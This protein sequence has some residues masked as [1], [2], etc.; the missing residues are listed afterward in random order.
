MRSTVI[1]EG[2]LAFFEM[3]D[4]C[5]GCQVSVLVVCFIM[6]R[7]SLHRNSNYLSLLIG[8][9]E[10][11]KDCSR[12]QNIHL[13]RDDYVLVTDAA[14]GGPLVVVVIGPNVPIHTKVEDCRPAQLVPSAG[15]QL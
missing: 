3:P 9:D 2:A 13:P 1:L 5:L 12:D 7:R 10:C 8:R 14:T 4:V 15:F 11:R 6:N